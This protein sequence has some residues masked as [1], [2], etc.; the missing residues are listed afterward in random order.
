MITLRN[1]QL[2]HKDIRIRMQ[3]AKLALELALSSDVT[4]TAYFTGPAE[5]LEPTTH[6]GRNN[7]GSTSGVDSGTSMFVRVGSAALYGAASFLITVVNKTVLTTYHFPSYQ[8]LG[9]GQMAATIVILYVSKRLGLLSFPHLD[10]SVFRKIWPLPFIYIGNLVFGLG[11]TKELSLPMLTVLRRFSILMTMIGELYFLG[12]RPSIAVQVSVYTMIAGAVVAASND[13]AFSPMGYTLVLLNDAFT[14][15][16]GVCM[17][18]KLDSAELGKH[19]VMF[20]NALFMLVPAIALAWIT[21][22]LDRASAFPGWTDVFFLAQFTASCVMGCV[23]MYTIILCTMHN[24]ALTTTVIGCLKNICITYLGM[25]IGGD[26]IFSWVNFAGINI[27]V[28]G[29]LLYSW[30]TFKRPEKPASKETLTV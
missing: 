29:S 9:L 12:I 19:G 13:L 10:S 5:H 25:M 17:K 7:M 4:Q 14:A 6:V 27:S 8:V 30:I 22:D 26:Y 16:N 20:Y 3:A 21:G 2:D 23:L 1:Q 18:S 28:A 24:S 11:G 15:A